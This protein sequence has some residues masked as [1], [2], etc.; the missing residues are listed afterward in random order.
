MM[1]NKTKH[2][3]IAWEC[4]KCHWLTISDS[5]ERNQNDS[6][7][8]GEAFLDLEGEYSRFNEFYKPLLINR[9]D[10]RGWK[11]VKKKRGKRQEVR[12]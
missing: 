8:C 9:F 2:R 5:R 12:E 3:L 1:I 6:C 4:I 10:G 11:Q 7:R